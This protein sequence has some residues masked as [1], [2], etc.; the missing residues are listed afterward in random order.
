MR[1]FF[2][3]LG[4]NCPRLNR[5]KYMTCVLMGNKTPYYHCGVIYHNVSH[6]QTF[7]VFSKK[8]KLFPW[9]V[10]ADCLGGCCPNIYHRARMAA[11]ILHGAFWS[12]SRNV[13]S[14]VT[15]VGMFLHRLRDGL[16][17]R[18]LV[19]KTG[20]LCLLC[21]RGKIHSKGSLYTHSVVQDNHDKWI[22]L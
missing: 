6:Y 21:F 11:V 4:L 22:P 18:A 13:E 7:I 12:F 2:F 15:H 17:Q 20:S 1:C 19:G 16:G 3:L 9:L 10:E 5:G 8:E 14:R